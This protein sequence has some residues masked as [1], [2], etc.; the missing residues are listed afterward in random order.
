MA[1]KSTILKN[2]LQDVGTKNQLFFMFGKTPNTVTSNT[3]ET[4]IDV[5]K[6]SDLSFKVARKDSVAVIPKIE[7]S[8]GNVYNTW[9]TKSL[10]TGSYYAW[11]KIN[12]LV[13]LCVSNNGLNRKDLSLTNA[14]T[15]IPS[16]SYGLVSYSDGYTWLP[17]YK[18]TSDLLRFVTS[19]W[20][21]VISFDDYRLNE[22]SRYTQAQKFCTN[23]Q[24]AKGNCAVYFKKTTQIPSTST[25]FSTNNKGTKYIT[26]SDVDCGI[27]YYL[28]EGSDS[29]I[30]SFSTG[31]PPATLI[32]KDRFDEVSELVENKTISPSS[33]Y[34]S[35][36]QIANNGLDDGALVSALIDLSDFDEADLVVTEA[37]PLITTSSGTGTGASLR[38][39]TYVNIDGEHI[40]NGVEILNTGSGYRDLTL[41][42]SS[43]K[44]IYLNS[45][46]ID[47]LLAS[48][49]LNL[50]TIDGLNF[51]PVSALGAENIMFDIRLETN[52]MVQDGVVIPDEINF[53]GLV[54]NPIENLGSGLEIIAGSQYGKDLSYTEPTTTKVELLS[55]TPP[56][57]Y[58]RTTITTTTG[59]TITDA[60]IVNLSASGGFTRADLAGIN[61]D[62]AQTLQTLTIDS[63]VYTVKQIIDYPVLKQYTGKVAQ[64]KKLASP[65]ILGNAD[66]DNQNTKIFRINIVKGF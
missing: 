18:I 57:N 63:I 61:Y 1:N 38:F 48:I 2:Y 21:P 11:N 30:T 36:Y 65:L 27:C 47:S 8:S 23:D 6:N 29:F 44:F 43:S 35:L 37:N 64:S 33:A 24:S 15:Q 56:K 31:T 42:I 25:T 32:I 45:V 53:Y 20:M 52:S 60:S 16:H 41:S 51:D 19:S 7:W 5:W 13:Y 50:D 9:S 17:L 55:G 22:P 14:S 28:Y 3:D 58:G 10:N 54:E 62:D 59:K 40:I 34:Y 66:N 4:A 49:E 12:G 46:E 26:I 39:T